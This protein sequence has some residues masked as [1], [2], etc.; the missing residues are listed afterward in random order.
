MNGIKIELP[1][2]AIAEICKRHQVRELSVFGSA[3][4]DDFTADSDIDFLVEFQPDAKIGFLEFAGMQIELAELLG[5]KVDLV[6]K[7]GLNPV[8]R[9]EILDSSKVFYAA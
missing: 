4:R 6:S 9:D 2:E 8:I 7:N 3:V 1:Q 5:R